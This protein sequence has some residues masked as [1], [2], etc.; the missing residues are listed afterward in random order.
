MSYYRRARLG[1]STTENVLLS[2]GAN[3]IVPGSGPVVAASAGLL[4]KLF[5]GSGEDARRQARV[6]WFAL[7]ASQGSVRAAR[8]LIGGLTNT[9]GNERPM[10]QA[11]IAKLQGT[12]VMQQAELQ[13]PWWDTS[14][15]AS[16]DKSRAA[17]TADLAAAG[18]AVSTTTSAAGGLMLPGMQ[19]TAAFNYVPWLIGGAAVVGVFL[20]TGRS[21]R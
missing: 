21:R 2:F 7:M 11:A 13:G 8:F 9:S 17:V 19:S 6:D 1:L 18:H 14:D 4:A 20:F 15:N 16:S 12:A 10:F 5:G 3:A